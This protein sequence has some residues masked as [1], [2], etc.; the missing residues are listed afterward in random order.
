MTLVNADYEA[1]VHQHGLVTSVVGLRFEVM[2]YHFLAGKMQVRCVSTI[3]TGRDI[4]QEKMSPLIDNRE[5]M[6]LAGNQPLR[7]VCWILSV[8]QYQYQCTSEAD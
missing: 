8:S 6:L 7:H 2:P 5:A 1:A 3:S 4:L